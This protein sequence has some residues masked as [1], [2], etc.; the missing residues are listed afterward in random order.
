MTPS[1]KARLAPQARRHVGV[2]MKPAQ[3]VVACQKLG[4]RL[5]VE[6]FGEFLAGRR[7]QQVRRKRVRQVAGIDAARAQKAAGRS[8][9]QF[10]AVVFRERRRDGFDDLVGTGA[11]HVRP[12][13]GRRELRRLRALCATSRTDD[14]SR[15]LYVY[16]D[17]VRREL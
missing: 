12:D 7:G 6:Q 11:F 17:N 9:Q 2:Q 4:R 14:V 5:R 13:R 10:A 16:I 1:E 8:A 3:S 15:D